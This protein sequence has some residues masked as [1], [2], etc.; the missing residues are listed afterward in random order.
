MTALPERFARHALALRAERDIVQD[1][2]V[3]RRLDRVCGHTVKVHTDPARRGMVRIAS[4]RRG[5]D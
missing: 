1:R 5:M 4:G 2:L 3:D